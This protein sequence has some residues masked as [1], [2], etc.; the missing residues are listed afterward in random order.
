MI[1]G[2]RIALNYKKLGIQF[3]KTFIYLDNPQESRVNELVRYFQN[4]KSIVHHVRVIGNWD[5]E[6]EF[7][8]YSEAEFDMILDHLK[9]PFP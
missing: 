8:V 6:P 2:F 7:E 9:F 4:N 5:L 3:Y 1:T